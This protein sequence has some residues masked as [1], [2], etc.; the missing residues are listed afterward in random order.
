ML[1]S[2]ATN[3]FGSYRVSMA[4]YRARR[5]RPDPPTCQGAEPD[6][7][8]LKQV[9]QVTTLVVEGPA[10]QDSEHGVAVLVFIQQL[11]GLAVISLQKQPGGAEGVR[12]RRAVRQCYRP[13]PAVPRPGRMGCRAVALPNSVRLIHNRGNL[14]CGPDFKVSHYPSARGFAEHD[15]AAIAWR[16]ECRQRS[17]CPNPDLPCASGAAEPLYAVGVHGRPGAPVPQIAAARAQSQA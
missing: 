15:P 7:H 10:G 14:A 5:A 3:D 12:L 2:A 16:G 13:H 8:L 6:L 9:E 11:W 4:D 17:L 1:S